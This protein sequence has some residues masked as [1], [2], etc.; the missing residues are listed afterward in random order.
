LYND[1]QEVPIFLFQHISSLKHKQAIKDSDF[2]DEILK[3][4]HNFG[5]HARMFAKV[6]SFE[7]LKSCLQLNETTNFSENEREK[8][9]TFEFEEPELFLQK[10]TK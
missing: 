5:N 7:E 10:S 8:Q 6:V 3:L 2:N 1:Y 9:M 4:C